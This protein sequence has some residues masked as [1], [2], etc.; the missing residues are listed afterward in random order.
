MRWTGISILSCTP[1]PMIHPSATAV[2]SRRAGGCVLNRIDVGVDPGSG[3]REVGMRVENKS[4]RARD[5][6]IL[7]SLVITA[8]D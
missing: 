6:N 1:R 3:G 5:R 4:Q 2:R 7:S 8:A